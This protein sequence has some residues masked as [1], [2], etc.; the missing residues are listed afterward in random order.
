MYNT[1]ITISLPVDLADKITNAAIN[2]KKSRSQYVRELIENGMEVVDCPRQYGTI[3][4]RNDCVECD[5]KDC[6]NNPRHDKNGCEVEKS[7]ALIGNR[8]DMENDSP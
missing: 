4:N 5:D 7:S 3:V 8:S 1:F 6:E 2:A